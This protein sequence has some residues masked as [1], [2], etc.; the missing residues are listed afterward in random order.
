MTVKL[1]HIADLHAG[2][3]TARKLPRNDELS[4][5][6]EQV[7][8]VIKEEKADY[9]V[10]AGDVFDKAVP[11]AESEHLIYDFL[12]KVSLLGTKTVVIGGNHDSWRR[13]KNIV[14]WGESF[15][16][17]VFP[18]L[19]IENMVFIDG[20][21]AFAAVPFVSERAITD[22]ENGNDE[23]ARL[24]YAEKM[25][26]LLRYAASLVKGAKYRIL[27]AHL[28]FGGAKVGNSERELTVTDAYAIP[29]S[30][31]P[32]E[33]HYAALGHIHRYQRLDGSPAHAFYTGSLYQL[34]FGESFQDKFFN[35]VVFEDHSV[36]EITPIK[37]SLKRK[38]KKFTLSSTTE[39][40]NLLSED[41]PDS[42]YWVVVKGTTQAEFAQIRRKLERFLKERL[43]K[44]SVESGKR[45]RKEFQNQTGPKSLNLSDP[46]EVYRA[47]LKE[48]G[49]GVEPELEGLL[50]TLYDEVLRET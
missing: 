30:A 35:L 18:K 39:V 46:V 34:D 16:I 6:L 15:S 7:L 17:K 11:D 45:H 26:K 8:A 48:K 2:K 4:H 21:V 47:Y 12:V 38:L 49:K 50:K 40:D 19:D 13:L 41:S 32:A 20:E 33:F 44:L 28:F 23:G 29:Q 42:Y 9:L 25:A 22:L 14:P 43:L 1:V 3:I 27:T 31:I 5:A 36:K 37:V 10:V 24:S